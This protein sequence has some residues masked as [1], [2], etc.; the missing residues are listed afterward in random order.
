MMA[1]EANAVDIAQFLRQELARRGAPMTAE[2][3]N[4]LS[5]AYSR[6]GTSG[7]EGTELDLTGERRDRRGAPGSRDRR[8]ATYASD[9]G[10]VSTRRG[11]TSRSV[12]RPPP[13]AGNTSTTSA[14]PGQNEN[15]PPETPAA[16]DGNRTPNIPPLASSD[17]SLERPRGLNLFGDRESGRT[18]SD[19]VTGSPGGGSQTVRVPD[20]A[21][22]NQPKTVPGTNVMSG[23]TASPAAVRSGTPEAQAAPSSRPDVEGTP[24]TGPINA[25]EAMQRTLEGPGADLVSKLVLGMGGR[26]FGMRGNPFAAAEGGGG[27]TALRGGGPDSTAYRMPGGPDS[28]IVQL[29]QLQGPPPP[30]MPVPSPRALS[31]PPPGL[32]A[33]PTGLPAPPAG[34]PSP[35]GPPV[36]RGMGNPNT[37][38]PPPVV[39]LQEGSQALRMSGPVEEA[40]ALG[41]ALRTRKPRAKKAE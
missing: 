20:T 15:K 40:R 41:K 31:A 14:K 19:L 33:P 23:S 12:G 30:G 6:E 4:R 8:G 16:G 17:L 9:E 26:G 2:N 29:P 34:L 27:G 3:L 13:D 22:G 5:L 38:S 35:M 37:A 21:A 36:P 1:D 24:D 25:R 18:L 28:R 39:P 10:N 7:A 11:D 32:P